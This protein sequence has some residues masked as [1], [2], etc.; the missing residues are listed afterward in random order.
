MT[1]PEQVSRELLLLRLLQEKVNEAT[2]ERRAEVE[3]WSQGSK[4]VINVDNPENPNRP[5]KVGEVRLD[6]GATV[7]VVRDRAAWET[8]A[9]QN[10]PHQVVTQ[11][12]HVPGDDIP[13]AEQ[14]EALVA[15]LKA[16]QEQGK[17]FA[18]DYPGA[19]L[20]ALR[21]AGWTLMK[22][23]QVPERTVVQPGYEN[24]TLRLSKEAGE[25]VTPEGLIPA[26]IEVTTAPGRAYI[27][28]TKDSYVAERF[29]AEMRAEAEIEERLGL[30]LDGREAES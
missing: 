12:A 13:T 4:I 22:L 21:A 27:T 17:R 30:A 14:A 11:P 7:A 1:A 29:V 24:A 9:K 26:G 10:A 2:G 16:A 15:A 20:R 3:R 23:E 5:Y 8:W 18:P 19:M 28:A 25:P 6:K